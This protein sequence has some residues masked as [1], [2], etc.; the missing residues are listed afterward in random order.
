L[1]FALSAVAA[2]SGLALLGL[3]MFGQP[4]AYLR[5]AREQ[6][7][8]LMDVSPPEVAPDQEGD[9]RTAAMADKVAQL[10]KQLAQLRDELVAN[11]VQA[12]QAR[13]ALAVAQAQRQA[14]ET[15]RQA[16]ESSRATADAQRPPSEASRPTP[17]PSVAPQQ[18]AETPPPA[19]PVSP[20]AAPAPLSATP[21]PVQQGQQASPAPEMQPAAP[22]QVPPSESRT[23]AHSRA[24]ASESA[25]RS[26]APAP[27]QPPAARSQ[28]PEPPPASSVPVVTQPQAP[29]AVQ[30]QASPPP[31]P[32]T[33]TS[34][35]ASRHDAAVPERR[36]LPAERRDAAATERREPAARTPPPP[37]R[38][39][40]E[41]EDAQSVLARLRQAAPAAQ[42]LADQ[43]QPPA[44]RPVRGPSPW[45]RRLFAARSALAAGQIEDAR[46][47]LQEVQ[48]QLVF[49][50][51]GAADES[52]G[53]SRATQDVARALDSLGGNDLTQSRAYIDRA[54][55][56]SNGRPSESAGRD[57]VS[58][59]SGYAPAYPPY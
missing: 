15:Q 29:A 16:E 38:P 24:P 51:L 25:I 35:T 28:P 7:D 13:Q 32:Q 33:P 14:E 5:Q 53:A 31:L 23:A 3:A 30:P 48:L 39:R 59:R 12:D 44:E 26:Q 18:T 46:R 8:S 57:W 34:Q 58:P 49:R 37:S 41:T 36:Q 52:V 27:E 9:P 17:E 10:Q 4:N 19:T 20:P 2:A 22:S 47:L 11:R 56:D 1:R 54:I 21:A 55:G 42:P 45:L 50:P 40:P 6:W 43:A